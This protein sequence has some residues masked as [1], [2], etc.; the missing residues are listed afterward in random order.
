MDIVVKSPLVRHCSQGVWVLRQVE[1]A[2][3]GFNGAPGFEAVG[4]EFKNP[5][6]IRA[7]RKW[8]RYLFDVNCMDCMGPGNCSTSGPWNIGR[9]CRVFRE[10]IHRIVLRPL[11]EDIFT[12]ALGT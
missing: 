3:E 12:L 7:S 6:F 5:Q 2:Q 11:M 9:G 10:E 8:V 1:V 4:I